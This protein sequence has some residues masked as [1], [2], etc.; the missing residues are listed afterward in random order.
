MGAV[1]HADLTGGMVKVLAL[2]LAG[3]RVDE[4]DVLT[5][6]RPKSV[7]P[8]G[9][10][11][12]IIDFPMSN[13]M[14]SGI[15][16]VGILSQYRPL[17]LIN[18]IANGEPWDMV[19]RNRFAVL[20]PPYKGREA[21]D[22][23]KGTA[24]AVYQ[25]LD[26]I[27]MYNPD[28]ILI[29]SGDHI[30]KMDYQELIVFHL[31]NKSDLTIAFTRLPK[32]GAHRFG[33]AE[34]GGRDRRGG[35]VTRYLEKPR[36]GLLDWASLTI[37]LFRPAV[38]YEALEANAAKDS[39]EFGKDIIPALLDDSQVYGFKHAGYWGYTRSLEE[40]WQTNMD[41][42][43]KYP[44]IDPA[45]WR[46]RTNL[47]HRNIRDR[48]P[49]VVGRTARV[50]DALFY[51]GCTIHGTVVRS[52]LFPGVTVEE[53]AEVRDSILFFDT[54]VQREARIVRTI[55]DIETRV[56]PAARIGRDAKAPLTIV[57]T[58]STIPEATVLHPGVVVHP[59]LDAGR[60][61]KHEY[62]AG[63]VIK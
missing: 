1:R 63:E 39:H 51:S 27:K 43:G 37:Y 33:Q 47:A 46:I 5:F 2:I 34:I 20:L 17:H 61:T 44:R 55:A 42:L 3:G 10:L 36:K 38:L 62:Q 12:R 56:G 21:A 60:F 14:N 41:L 24:D 35:R 13:L 26:F 19:G 25:N 15:E 16:T 4:L 30:Y 29:I 22:W 9:G 7:M 49:T 50:E 40:Y 11:Y 45:Q 18:H 23:Y 8:F 31:Q 59:N 28:L 48:R 53:G 6:Y 58:R 57:G 32:E 54:V 52:V